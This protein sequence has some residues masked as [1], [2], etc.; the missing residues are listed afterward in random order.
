MSLSYSRR[1]IYLIIWL[2]FGLFGCNPSTDSDKK[3]KG[4][5]P[6]TNQP[7]QT[8]GF[9]ETR[10]AYFGCMHVHTSY[11]FDGSI[12]KCITLPDDAYRWAKGESIPGG[13]GRSD[14]Q[15]KVPLD[16]YAVSDHAE[17]LGIFNE[18]KNP[19]SPL[20]KLEIA[21]KMTSDDPAVSFEAFGDFL[22]SY[23]MGEPQDPLLFDPE[24]M[25]PIWKDIVETADQHY[26]PGQFTT[27]PAFEW[28][29]NPNTR[30]LHRVVVFMNSQHVPDLPYSSTDSERPEDLWKWMDQTRANGATLLAIPHN[31]NASDG[32]MFSMN[33][34]DGNPI[35]AEYSSIRMKNEP[36]YEISQIKGT[37]ETHPDLSPND[38]F[39]DFE[40][41]DYTLAATAERPTHRA[42]SFIRRALQ[43][44]MLLQSQ[45]KGNPFKYGVIGDSDTHNSGASVEEDNYTGK[46]AMENDPKDRL[47]PELAS[48][49][50]NQQIREFSSGGLAG[51]WAEEN[52]RESIFSAMM[53][54]ETFGTSGTRLKVRCFGSFNYP[55][56]IMDQTDWLTQAYKYGT[57][58]GGSLFSGQQ[59]S[60]TFLIHAVKEANGA[61]LDRTQVIKLWIDNSG[62]IQE[63]VYEAAWSDNRRLDKDGKLPPVGNTVDVSKATYTNEIGDVELKSIWTDPDF[64]PDQYACYYVRVLE[65]PT[66]RWSTYD[67]VTLGIP[68]RDDLPKTIQERAWTSPIWYEPK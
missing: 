36:L 35:S 63:K 31:A 34:S 1:Y 54:K 65:I 58:M 29:S 66:P 43:D 47:T 52:T 44:G 41:W 51:V 9:S 22:Y 27:F 42:G 38:E 24:I 18:M 23:S 28:S 11:S 61:N 48:E 40:E 7:T 60:P 68:P 57:P 19:A 33:D 49:A 62:E 30:N 67:A 25:K 5:S 2:S 6:N 17:F 13:K 55:D 37:S 64:N 32:L 50:N 59:G 16:F 20:S 46:F 4:S 12:N 39:A 14:L 21:K 45:G 8:E 3:D 15:I 26:E 56:G 10:N 53:R